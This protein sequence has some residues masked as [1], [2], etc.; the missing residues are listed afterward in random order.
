M[1]DESREHVLLIRK[2]KP[3]WQEGLYNGIGGKVQLRKDINTNT[4]E[5]K[6]YEDIYLPIYDFRKDMSREFEEEV[7]IKTSSEEWEYCLEMYNEKFTVFVYRCF[8][9]NVHDYRQM[10]EEVPCTFLLSQWTGR[11]C[12]NNLS[13]I[14]PML[15][16]NE[17]KFPL[18]VP[19]K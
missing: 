10:E 7:G 19:Y 14:I 16:D 11:G 1:F 8:S 9:D 17:L 4:G 2:N 12:I 15:L 18:K 3:K 5:I 13:W 6:Q